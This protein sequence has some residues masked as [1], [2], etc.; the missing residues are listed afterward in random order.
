MNLLPDPERLQLSPQELLDIERREN[1]ADPEYRARF[2][3][4]ALP[5]LAAFWLSVAAGVFIVVRGW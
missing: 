4:I 1:G 2:W 5:L 3:R